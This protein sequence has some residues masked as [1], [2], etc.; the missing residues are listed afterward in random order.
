MSRL[1]SLL[2]FLLAVTTAFA[3]VATAAP[4][5]AVGAE[6]STTI[7]RSDDAATAQNATVGRIDD[8]AD[9]PNETTTRLDV[10]GALTSNYS[11]VDLDFGGTMA[12]SMDGI[13]SRYQVSIVAVQLERATGRSAQDAA[14]NAYLDAAVEELDALQTAE[15]RAVERYRNGDITA[16]SLLLRLA[17]VDRRARAIQD[18]LTRI[19]TSSGSLPRSTLN[20]IEDV[21]LELGAFTTPIREH[22]ALAASGDLKG[23]VNPLRVTVG[24]NGVVVEMLNDR[25]YVRNA[26]RFDDRQVSAVDRLGGLDAFQDRLEEAYPWSYSR[27]TNLD[28]DVYTAR[29]LY[30]A[31]YLHPQGSMETFVDGGTTDVFREEQSLIL[32]RLPV[33]TSTAETTNNTTVRVSRTPAD[34]PVLVNV[35][36]SV[37]NDSGNVTELPADAVV[38]VNGYEV[39]HTGDDG[40]LWLLAPPTNYE[41]AV[42]HGETTVNVSVSP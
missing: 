35:T 5:T 22:V 12:M 26:V 6:A 8:G 37:T 13:G 16:E 30:V 23:D 3:P 21:R 42:V 25:R 2:V 18:S 40:E 4:A 27:K 32:S 36:E 17:I 19:E 41:I 9:A 20:R 14:V 10:S 1:A 28:V 7:D 31:N 39:G 11:T 24:Q 33:E 15:E 38:E 29:N 34:G